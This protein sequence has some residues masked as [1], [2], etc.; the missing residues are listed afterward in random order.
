MA[1]AICITLVLVILFVPALRDTFSLVAL[2]EEN[3]L[4]IITL[5]ISP[6]VVVEVLK[7]LKLNTLKNEE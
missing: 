6:L 4:E 2:P 3:I 5:V 1:V 7:L